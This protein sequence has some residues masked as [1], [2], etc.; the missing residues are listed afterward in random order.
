MKATKYNASGKKA[1]QVDLSSAVF[2]EDYSKSAIY[3]V[4]RAELANRRQGTHKT[5]ERAEVRGGGK[6]PW[7]QKGTGNARQGSTRAPN[8]R[9]GGTVFGPRPRSYRIDLPDKMRKA[10]IRSIL[11]FKALKEAINV[12]EDPQLDKYSTKQVYSIFK[13]MEMV[14]SGTVAFVVH[15]EDEKLK[16]STGN[17]PHIRLINAERIT[18]PELFYSTQVVITE[19]A[20]RVLEDRYAGSGKKEVA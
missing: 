1:G 9:G 16:K 7:R 11:S 2:I 3:D 20:L 5:K 6:K 12:L 18:A 8:W 4:I 13:S 14:P 10:G 19:S 15:G 17:I